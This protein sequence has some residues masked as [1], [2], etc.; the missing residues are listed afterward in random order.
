M[1]YYGGATTHRTGTVRPRRTQKLTPGR[2]E[3]RNLSSPSTT[4]TLPFLYRSLSSFFFSRDVLSAISLAP[5]HLNRAKYI[6]LSSHGFVAK[7]PL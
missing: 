2:M 4:S 6:I 3:L 7:Y 5:S 1:M